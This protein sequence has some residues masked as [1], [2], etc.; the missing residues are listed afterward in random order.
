MAA[1]RGCCYKVK[2]CKEARRRT[3]GSDGGPCRIRYSWQRANGKRATR[4]G[5][6]SIEG[7]TAVDRGLLP[8]G[9]LVKLLLNPVDDA[10]DLPVS[11]SHS[12]SWHAT[13]RFECPRTPSCGL[14]QVHTRVPHLGVQAASSPPLRKKLKKGQGTTPSP[15]VENPMHQ[16]NAGAPSEQLG[17]HRG[18]QCSDWKPHVCTR[19]WRKPPVVWVTPPAPHRLFW[20]SAQTKGPAADILAPVLIWKP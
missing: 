1:R 8:S 13:D 4:W 10:L 12:E 6:A 19:C 3:T 17:G 14:C 16:S 18:Q 20:G 11:Q 7:L 5:G 9:V 2:H 15:S